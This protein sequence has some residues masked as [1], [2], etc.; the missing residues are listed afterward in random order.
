MPEPQ[1]GGAAGVHDGGPPDAVVDHLLVG[2]AEH[3]QDLGAFLVVG[4]DCAGGDEAVQ[5]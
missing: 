3:E 1:D 4:Q 2:V 5:A